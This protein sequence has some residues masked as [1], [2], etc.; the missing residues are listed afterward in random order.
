MRASRTGTIA[1][2]AS[3]GHVSLLDAGSLEE[4][5]KKRQ[6]HT[7][8]ITSCVFKDDEKMLITS[9][10]DYK[11]CIIPQNPTSLLSYVRNMFLNMAILLIILLYF[12]EW[13]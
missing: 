9:G 4:T 12:A 3:D 11:Y 8:P 2:L 13:L 10:L 7:M 6:P 5:T 1:V